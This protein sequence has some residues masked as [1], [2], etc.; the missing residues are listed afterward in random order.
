MLGGGSG[1]SGCSGGYGLAV[2]TGVGISTV[3]ALE[4]VSDSERG[5]WM[6]KVLRSEFS[7]ARTDVRAT[8][9]IA[10]DLKNPKTLASIQRSRRQMTRGEGRNWRDL[11]PPK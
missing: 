9:A 8:H 6:A 11:Y 5:K 4:S 10:R 7:A 3:F 1:G 2:A